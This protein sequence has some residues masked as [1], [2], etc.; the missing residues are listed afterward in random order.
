[1]CDHN[2]LLFQVVMVL[3]SE[4]EGLI[5]AQHPSSFEFDLNN[6]KCKSTA[7]ENHSGYPND[8]MSPRNAL[9]F[10][11]SGDAWTAAE[12]T[13]YSTHPYRRRSSRA[14]RRGSDPVLK[15]FL[16]QLYKIFILFNLL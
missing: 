14:T 11:I 13:F 1:M 6:N 4:G 15:N 2:L 16:Y 7:R 9:D 8:F 10:N 5:S 3:Y 12:A